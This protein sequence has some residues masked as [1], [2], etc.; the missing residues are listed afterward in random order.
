MRVLALILAFT[1]FPGVAEAAD[2]LAHYVVEGHTL[3]EAAVVEA[4]HDGHE[5]HEKD[6]GDDEHGCSVLFHLCGCHSPTPSQVTVRLD[7]QKTSDHQAT[8]PGVLAFLERRPRD[9]VR[10]EAFRPPIA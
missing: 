1:V 3:H 4:A 7:V 10:N 5:G 6:H 9:G 8:V 2:D